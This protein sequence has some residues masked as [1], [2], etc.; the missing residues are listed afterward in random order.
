MLTKFVFD[1]FAEAIAAH[2]K[3][4]KIG[5]KNKYITYAEVYTIIYGEGSIDNLDIYNRFGWTN[6]LELKP[7]EEKGKYV[8]EFPKIENLENIVKMKG[9]SNN[10]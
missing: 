9:E 2:Q 8:L 5:Y 10:E 4:F 1:G 7:K 3:I 6:L